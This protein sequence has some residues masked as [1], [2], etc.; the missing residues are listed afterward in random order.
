MNKRYCKELG[1]EI[2]E[3][4]CVMSQTTKRWWAICKTCE[5]RTYDECGLTDK[6]KKRISKNLEGEVYP[7]NIE[8]GL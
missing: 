3:R 2:G 1:W 5:H 4:S 8:E 7:N 6:I